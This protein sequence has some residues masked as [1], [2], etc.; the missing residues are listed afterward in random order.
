MKLLDFLNKNKNS[1]I[2]DSDKATLTQSTMT[3]LV[4]IIINNKKYTL[5]KD[6]YKKVYIYFVTGNEVL[7]YSFILRDDIETDY[8]LKDATGK[9]ISIQFLY[10]IDTE[11]A[12]STKS[13]PTLENY[14][15]I[16]NY[17]DDKEIRKSVDNDSLA[18]VAAVA[19]IE[20]LQFL[21]QIS[22]ANYKIPITKKPYE[23][24]NEKEDEQQNKIEQQEVVVEESKETKSENNIKDIVEPQ[25]P[26]Q[27]NITIPY[28]EIKEKTFEKIAEKVEEIKEKQPKISPYYFVGYKIKLETDPLTGKTNWHYELNKNKEP[29]KVYFSPKNI[30]KIIASHMFISGKTGS[31]KTSF[32]N[33]LIH[34]LLYYGVNVFAFDIKTGSL[35]YSSSII[36]EPESKENMLKTINDSKYKGVLQPDENIQFI[37]KDIP[38][39][40]L[41]LLN[42]KISVF[43]NR[44][45]KPVVPLILYNNPDE[46]ANIK[47]FTSVNILDNQL[48][49]DLIE[50]A[51]KG[52]E[53]IAEY[54]ALKQEYKEG[55]NDMLIAYFNTLVKGKYNKKFVEVLADYMTSKILAYM[56]K[57]Q[58]R[59]MPTNADFADWIQDYDMFGKDLKPDSE[60]IRFIDYVYDNNISKRIIDFEN[61]V[62]LHGILKSITERNSN[63]YLTIRTN[64]SLLSFY[65]IYLYYL[66]SKSEKLKIDGMAEG[67]AYS[68]MFI[69]EAHYLEKNQLLDNVLKDA[70]R[71]DRLRNRGW[72]FSSQRVFMSSFGKQESIGTYIF[73]AGQSGD[74][75]SQKTK[76]SKIISKESI[77]FI[78]SNLLTFTS[79]NDDL[80]VDE[81]G[82]PIDR[83]TTVVKAFPNRAFTKD[84]MEYG[85]T[86]YA[87]KAEP[88]LIQKQKIEGVFELTF[89]PLTISLKTL[90]EDGKLSISALTD[91]DRIK[92]L[93]IIND[94]TPQL[95]EALSDK[96]LNSKE[97]SSNSLQYIQKI[98]LLI[99]TNREL[100]DKVDVFI[101]TYLVAYKNTLNID[102]I[103]QLLEIF[104]D[105]KAK[106]N[107]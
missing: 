81:E 69:D 89:S 11:S 18:R 73:F 1:E 92:L 78:N 72:I 107:F 63:F 33:T 106:M 39:E 70:Q 44:F 2:K 43:K 100:S 10:N 88:Y 12:T 102:L 41:L 93:K 13:L 8:M 53:Y 95:I 35:D 22:F 30:G 42:P 75:A 3:G 90:S 6:V 47:Y 57:T 34:T 105:Y 85:V 104:E 28:S 45:G 98:L 19:M 96:D 68:A 36:N 79:D 67:E 49:N 31:G 27:Q 99:Q 52:N 91:D 29:M 71:T 82:S 103:K 37:D 16:K 21:T 15:R 58:F 38:D 54:N 84:I 20:G 86:E 14:T 4:T 94:L 65:V 51:S 97:I 17:L 101:K 48:R 25:K 76:F 59:V 23:K 32:N 26:S 77:D 66:L 24:Q 60:E 56:E 74:V 80:I 5:Y 62:D 46:S 61:G 87:K 64:I 40:A 55:I 9:N 83:F 7:L 50:Y